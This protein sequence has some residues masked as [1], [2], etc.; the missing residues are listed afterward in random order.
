[1]NS[2]QGPPQEGNEFNGII[3]MIIIQ[4]IQGRITSRKGWSGLKKFLCLVFIFLALTTY[5]LQNILSHEK[6]AQNYYEIFKLDRSANNQQIKKAIEEIR[7]ELRDNYHM[8]QMEKST[9]TLD[10]LDDI[11]HA[12]TNPVLR[13]IYDK[14]LIIVTQE[15]FK[16]RGNQFPLS[17]R[18]FQAFGQVFAKQFSMTSILVA[19]YLAVYIKLPKEGEKDNQIA[20]FMNKYSLLMNLTFHEIV[21]TLANSSLIFQFLIIQKIFSNLFHLIMSVSRMIDQH[22]L[23]ELS[24]KLK[25]FQ[26][27]SAKC[28]LICELIAPLRQLPSELAPQDQIQDENQEPKDQVQDEN[29]DGSIVQQAQIIK[30]TEELENEVEKKK[31]NYIDAMKFVGEDRSKKFMET[32]QRMLDK[33]LQEE[34][35]TSRL[36][37]CCRLLGKVAIGV[38]VLAIVSPILMSMYQQ[39][40]SQGENKDVKPMSFDE[41]KSQYGGANQQEQQQNESGIDDVLEDYKA[42]MYQFEQEQFNEN[43]QDL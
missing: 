25:S 14:S 27:L 1:M 18:Y 9:L 31:K 35:Q 4:T 11:E 3:K 41:F 16:E 5:D 36:R 29:Q 7:D 42:E 38:A 43:N 15:E 34:K 30:S 19:I 32:F 6:R 10:L 17:H 20:D 22:P 23:E 26:K 37:K 2:N 8:Y 40:N 33:K 21:N 39:Y 12:L 13:D 28:L 24:S